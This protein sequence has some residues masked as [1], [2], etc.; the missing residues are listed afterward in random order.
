MPVFRIYQQRL[1]NDEI[2]EL[3]GPN[4]GWSAKP[5]FKAYAD[6]G[7]G[8]MGATAP[9]LNTMVVDATK[10]GIYTHVCD[11]E[12]DDLEHAFMI[13][14]N[15]L[16]PMDERVVTYTHMT[17]ICVGNIAVNLD[18]PLR[19]AHFCDGYGWKRLTQETSQLLHKEG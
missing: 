9:D 17:S 4:G 2:E 8:T 1:T 19:P 11:I 5:E 15:D 14:N 12:A 13:G 3:N 16:G 18:D 7:M 6:V 10:L